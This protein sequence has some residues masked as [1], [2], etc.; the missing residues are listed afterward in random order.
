M[1]GVS[2]E[3]QLLLLLDVWSIFCRPRLEDAGVYARVGT[4]E[5]PRVHALGKRA[6]VFSARER[7]DFG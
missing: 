1:F 5:P 2:R 4:R 7:G 6:S 3:R